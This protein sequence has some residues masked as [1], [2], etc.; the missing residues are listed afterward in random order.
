MP[1]RRLKEMLDSKGVR[2]TI[3]FHSPAYTAQQIA[4][5][6][7]IPGKQLAKTVMVKLD[8]RLSMAVVPASYRVDLEAL[9]YE[10]G[11]DRATLASEVDF[12]DIFPGCEV[13]AMPPF[14]NLFQVPVYVSDTLA[15]DA[16]ISFNAG[17]HTE[18]MTLAFRDFE[19]LVEPKILPFSRHV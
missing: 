16:L 3:L 13:G 17:N 2:Y 10:T 8:G 15:E 7:H 11:A 14:G 9:A 1:L 19:R 4:Q 5:A 18:V 6:A 12:R